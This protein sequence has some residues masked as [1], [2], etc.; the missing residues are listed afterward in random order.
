M[1]FMVRLLLNGS[2]NRTCRCTSAAIETFVCVDYIFAITFG[3]S[4]Y[5]ALSCTCA[6]TDAIIIDDI[7]HLIHL[8]KNCFIKSIT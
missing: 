2:T 3:N 5:G 6:A 8:L 4:R 7:C 1:H